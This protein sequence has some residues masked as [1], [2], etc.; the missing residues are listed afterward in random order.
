MGEQGRLARIGR[1]R[2][3]DGQPFAQT[4]AAPVRDRQAGLGAHPVDHLEDLRF[5]V[6]RHIALIGEV[7]AR[8]EQRQDLQH[9]LAPALGGIPQPPPELEHGLSA[10][11]LGLGVDDVG[12]AFHLG[13]VHASVEKSPARELAGFRRAAVLNRGERAQNGRPGRQPAMDLE[14]GLI[15]AGET[16]RPRHPQDQGLIEGLAAARVLQ[17]AHR[18]APG[19]GHPAGHPLQDRA[20]LRSADPDQAHGGAAIPRGDRED[21][22]VRTHEHEPREEKRI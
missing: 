6:L 22:V 10:L 5:Q 3:H 7:E 4:L 19:L 2:Q 18:R 11:R 17:R 13:K 8:F 9:A 15:L 16:P 21:G 1:A 12:E 20:A 14:L